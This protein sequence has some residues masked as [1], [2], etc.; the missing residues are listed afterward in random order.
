MNLN[1]D[2]VSDTL[3][4]R[5]DGSSEGSEN[6]V[7][8]Q[9]ES[10]Q[11]DGMALFRTRGPAKGASKIEM[12]DDM[13][14]VAVEVREDTPT[15]SDRSSPAPTT[16]S[17]TSMRNRD[18]AVVTIHINDLELIQQAVG[19]S[20]SVR[21]Q[22]GHLSLSECVA[23]SRDEFQVTNST[24]KFH[25]CSMESIRNQKRSVGLLLKIYVLLSHCT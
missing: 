5:S 9:G 25:N 3:S 17:F 14:E 6:F 23:I 7:M 16:T 18:L 2:D 13:L 12:V 4:M 15:N 20:T 24:F 10:E 21:L 8:L 11:A 22:A 1:E 19:A